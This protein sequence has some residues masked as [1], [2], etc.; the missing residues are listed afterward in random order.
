MRFKSGVAVALSLAIAPS[1][2]AVNGCVES[3]KEKITHVYFA[4][5]ILTEPEAADFAVVDLKDAYKS[6]LESVS[7]EET[8]RF[9]KAYNQTQSALTDIV[10]VLQQKQNELGVV[11]EGLSAYQVYQW[12][13]AGLSVEEVRQLIDSMSNL[14]SPLI[15]ADTIT[16][17]NLEALSDAMLSA[18]ADAM[19][20]RQEVNANHVGYYEADLLSG[21]RVIV[22]AHSQGNLF[23]NQALSDVAMRNYDLSQSIGSVGVASP[24]GVTV[25]GNTYTTAHDDLVIDGLRLISSVLPS[26]VENDPGVFNDFRSFTNHYFEQ[27]YFDARLP[28]RDVIDTEVLRLADALPYPQ[29]EAGEGAI[30][31]SLTW[32]SQPDVDLH[33]FEPNGAHV[34]YSNRNG[35][36]GSLDVDD[37]T[38]YGPENYV[39][40]C[41][42]VRLGTYEIAVNYFRGYEPETAKV[43]LFLGDG[44]SITP[45]EI[46]LAS[47]KGAEGD[48][49]PAT[50]FQIEVSE[51]DE[52]KVTYTVN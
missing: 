48:N 25:N 36:D 33:A 29:T 9:L 4:N 24:A 43:A 51:N 45:K 40:A 1:F 6:D 27:D 35:E 32:G 52:G 47:A 17:E 14:A 15:L 3:E 41:E 8:F 42:D 23:T 19:Y 21:K 11:D 28:S 18:A 30:R 39:V 26:N 7:S 50:V 38:S 31:A 16:E 46:N 12:V 22:I 44:R 49:N 37:T 5:G 34:Y 2:A 13:Q 10:Q 20:D